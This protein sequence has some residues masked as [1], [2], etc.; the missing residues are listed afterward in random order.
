MESANDPWPLFFLA[1]TQSTPARVRHIIAGAMRVALIAVFAL[2]VVGSLILVNWV[3]PFESWVGPKDPGVEVM[4]AAHDLEV[5]TVIDDYD[6]KIVRI[7]Q[8]DLPPGAPR[9]RSDVLG[10]K[11]IMPIAK[12][13]F[14]LPS[15]LQ[16]LN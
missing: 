12:G 13:E 4:V 6:I 16:A 5:G 11:V 9:R 3:G 8:V 7:P 1:L 2:G 14:I 10:H 15:R